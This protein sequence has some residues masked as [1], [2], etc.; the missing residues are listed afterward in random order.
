MDFRC[1]R[2]F[3]ALALGESQNGQDPSGARLRSSLLRAYPSR[4]DAVSRRCAARSS[5]F[6]AG[7]P[8]VSGPVNLWRVMRAQGVPRPPPGA[9]PHLRCGSVSGRGQ[10]LNRLHRTKRSPMTYAR[11]SSPKSTGCLGNGWGLPGCSVGRCDRRAGSAHVHRP[12]R[13]TGNSPNRAAR[14]R[15]NVVFASS[16]GGQSRVN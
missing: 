6:V 4:R 12:R 3:W 1:R 15:C 8:A 2:R 5:A 10:G 7:R 16:Q 11:K 14:L 13:M 9:E